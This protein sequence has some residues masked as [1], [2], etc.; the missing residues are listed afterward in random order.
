[1]VGRMD[2][3][4]G[5]LFV[6][7]NDKFTRQRKREG[8]VE[9]E[10]KNYTVMNEEE[11]LAANKTGNTFPNVIGEVVWKGTAVVASEGQP[12]SISVPLPPDDP[13]QILAD[14]DAVV[15][16]SHWA[17]TTVSSTRPSSP[18]GLPAHDPDDLI[19]LLARF[20]TPSF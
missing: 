17:P 13:Q 2:V 5:S 6:E 20:Q 10:N 3:G 11:R 14:L 9:E 1:M 15:Y 19:R 4:T 7:L 16:I 8:M 12:E 18:A